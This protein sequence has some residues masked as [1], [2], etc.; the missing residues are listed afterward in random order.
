LLIGRERHPAGDLVSLGAILFKEEDV[1]PGRGAEMAGVVVGIS[2]PGKTVVG[3]LVPF[4]ASDFAR[5]ASNAE[6]RVGKEADFDVIRHEGVPALVGTL[7][8]VADH[9]R[10][11]LRKAGKQEKN[12]K[13]ENGQAALA[14][15]RALREKLE[16]RCKEA[17][18]I[19]AFLLSLDMNPLT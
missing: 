5:F 2:G 7:V 1:T 14:R 8:A 10:E 6:G 15:P 13:A 12:S 9:E 17:C 16:L 11:S 3:H 18:D 19:P 4:F